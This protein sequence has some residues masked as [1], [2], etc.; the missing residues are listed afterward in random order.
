MVIRCQRRGQTVNGT[1]GASS[2][3]DKLDGGYVA[4]AY[5]ATGS[6]GQVA[7]TCP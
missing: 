7:P 1:Y 5:V 4:D 3:W 2:L 6:D